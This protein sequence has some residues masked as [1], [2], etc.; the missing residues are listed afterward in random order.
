LRKPPLTA[1]YHA[2]SENVFPAVLMMRKRLM[3]HPK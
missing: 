3:N 1:G 2:G